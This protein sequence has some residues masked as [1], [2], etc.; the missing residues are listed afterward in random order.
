MCISLQIFLCFSLAVQLPP[1]N[2][3]SCQIFTSTEI[4]ENV[5]HMSS[6][7]TAR[8][9]PAM[10]YLLKWNPKPQ[11]WL[12]SQTHDAAFSWGSL[13]CEK[14]QLKLRVSLF[15]CFTWKSSNTN[16][17]PQPLLWNSQKTY[18]LV[19]VNRSDF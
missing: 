3:C 2:F 18:S 17:N 7:A 16:I 12:P 19:F 14:Q 15:H 10:T 6:T 13:C 8:Q 11:C 5:V 9:P 1:L 4:T